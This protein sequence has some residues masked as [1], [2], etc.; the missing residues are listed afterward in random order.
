M[1]MGVPVPLGFRAGEEGT[2]PCSR[3]PQSC[4]PEA[5]VHTCQKHPWP[6]YWPPALNKAGG[7][8]GSVSAASIQSTWAVALGHF[9]LTH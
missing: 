7:S 6:R 3:K 2:G 8:W 9:L 4:L 1:G 5:H